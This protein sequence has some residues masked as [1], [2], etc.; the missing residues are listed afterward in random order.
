[1]DR[2]ESS[3][4]HRATRA[5]VLI[6]THPAAAIVAGASLS[7]VA[8]A[9]LSPALLVAAQALLLAGTRRAS[10]RDLAIAFLA[11]WLASFA[12]FRGAA[13]ELSG[14]DAAFAVT[15]GIGSLFGLA[16]LAIDRYLYSR[17]SPVL[18]SL[19]YPAARTPIEVASALLG[20]HGAW[21]SMAA[22]SAGSSLAVVVVPVAGMFGLSFLLSWLA[23]AAAGAAAALVEGRAAA[24]AR[25]L[26][27]A[28]VTVSLLTG[29]GASRAAYDGPT[30]R[31]AAVAL[32]D[33]ATGRSTAYERLVSDWRAGGADARD[34]LDAEDDRSVEAAVSAITDA[35]DRGATIVYVAEANVH[36]RDERAAA[37]EATMGALARS[38]RIW[39]G[40][41]VGVVL[42]GAEP[43]LRNE[44]VLFDPSGAVAARYAKA[45]A[46]GSE[47]HDM[48]R[49]NGEVP[50]RDAQGAR[51]A[52]IICFDS[53]FVTFTRSIARQGVDILFV[54]TNDW[55]AIAEMRAAVT[56]FRA[57]ETGAVLV[58]PASHGVSEIVAPDGRLLAL[59]RYDDARGTSLVAD[60]P[61][62]GRATAYAA[63]GDWPAVASL[64]LLAI[65]II[66][67]HLRQATWN[68]RR[69]RR[70]GR[71]PATESR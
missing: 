71:A 29:L 48:V 7:Y 32:A 63:A 25:G 19:V 49:G 31:V 70:A 35:A 64:G 16:T 14:G 30:V 12:V 5:V 56:R 44:I 40:L 22:L 47:T 20:P 1:M 2:L 13:H 21:G 46:I 60:V 67:W 50:V 51:I 62:R 36:V 43:N 58:R 17:L 65:L 61:A 4:R 52:G 15:M 34:A 24:A 39:I 42:P 26:S 10:R 69:T 68:A 54:P 18:A 37:L 59:A 8:R 57:L 45:H 33:A 27:P 38:R 23:S 3:T 66:A 53:D 55:R 11:T 28:V 41:G 6:V 9:S